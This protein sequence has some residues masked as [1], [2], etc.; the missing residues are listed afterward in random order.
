MPHDRLGLRER[1]HTRINLVLTI[2]RSCLISIYR[3]EIEVLRT[4]TRTYVK[5]ET[6]PARRNIGCTSSRIN[7][8]LYITRS[9]EDHITGCATQN[10]CN[11]IARIWLYYAVAVFIFDMLCN[12]YGA[13]SSCGNTIQRTYEV[14]AI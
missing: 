5:F 1:N 4:I 3:S 14:I 12:L 7:N 10:G 8:K 13:N 9:S 11:G 6:K 2:N